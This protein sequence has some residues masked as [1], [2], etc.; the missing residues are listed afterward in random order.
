MTQVKTTREKKLE[1]EVRDLRLFHYRIIAQ[2]A[3]LDYAI[4]RKLSCGAIE[5]E[6]FLSKW[7]LQFL[8][9]MRANEKK[10]FW[11]EFMTMLVGGK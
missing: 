2:K 11:K 7:S 5:P 8:P 4:I 1:K 9:K 3:F 6:S 10:A